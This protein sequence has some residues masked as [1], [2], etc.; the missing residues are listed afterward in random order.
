MGKMGILFQSKLKI[1]ILDTILNLAEI[2]CTANTMVMFIFITTQFLAVFK[3]MPINAL[4]H[5]A[6]N[7]R[8]N[9]HGVAPPKL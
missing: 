1:N 5:L 2:S 6:K 7:R 4:V 8:I 9:G 3:L